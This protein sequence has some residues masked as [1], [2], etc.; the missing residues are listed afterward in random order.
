M[1]PVVPRAPWPVS[2]ALRALPLAPL[3]LVISTLLNRVV[4]RHPEIFE[5]L[6]THASRRFG[7]DPTDMPFVMEL[8]PFRQAP[9]ITVLRQLPGSGIDA[10]VAGPLAGI[11]G[12]ASGAFDGDALFFS[13]D[14]V[15]EGDITALLA[16][17]NALDDTGIDFIDLAARYLGLLGI[18]F[19]QTARAQVAKWRRCDQ[20]DAMCSRRSQSR[21]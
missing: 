2:L 18:P 15:V 7:I 1:T 5:R 11:L 12:L 10:R 17:R 16:L 19:A 6:G 4:A 20:A 9:R 8:R 13:R 14:L 3:Q 21:M